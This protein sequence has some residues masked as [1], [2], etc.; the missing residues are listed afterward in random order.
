MSQMLDTWCGVPGKLFRCFELAELTEGG[1]G[2]SKPATNLSESTVTHCVVY[3][4][5]LYSSLKILSC[6]LLK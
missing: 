4:F 3:V 5:L 1:L 6:L 2:C